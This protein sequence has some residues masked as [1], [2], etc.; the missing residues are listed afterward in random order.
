M[1]SPL[2]FL[3]STCTA[4]GGWGYAPGY[5]PGVEPT[6][7]VLL[8]L[9]NDNQETLYKKTVSWLIEIQNADGGWGFN[10]L[11]QVSGWLSAWSVWALANLESSFPQVQKGINFLL[12]QNV[13]QINN[14][15][16]LAA[17]KKV[18]NIDFSLRGWPWRA[19][20][21]SWVEPT[22]LSV[23]ALCSAGFG[24]SGRVQ[25]AIDYLDNRRCPNGGWNVGNPV[26]FGEVL[27]ARAHPTAW[28][29][30]ALSKANPDKIL[31]LDLDTLKQEMDNDSG[32]MAVA[33]GCLAL[34]SCGV[35]VEST[36]LDRLT[37]NQMSDG[38][39]EQ[40]PYLTAISWLV[41]MGIIL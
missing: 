12:N 3:I 41:L 16:D 21:A 8:A 38:S 18:A 36:F 22:A 7:A 24:S 19:G 5:G 31:D 23:I 6:S 28:S 25:E 20:E 11:D 35:P 37:K 13:M 32:T 40:N 4:E 9:L 34:R 15:D 1:I 17:G 30:L 14:L 33:W 39:W 10:Q 27:P 29:L 26:M 2:D